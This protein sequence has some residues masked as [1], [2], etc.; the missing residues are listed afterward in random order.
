M[1]SESSVEVEKP[2][3]EQIKALVDLSFEAKSKAYNPY[4][5]F[6]VGAALLTADGKTFTG[7]HIIL[8]PRA[9]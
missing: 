2:S 7:M 8:V 3:E 9:L 1:A 6:R 5:N 4:S